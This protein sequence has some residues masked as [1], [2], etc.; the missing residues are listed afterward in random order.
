M[1]QW[2]IYF[3]WTNG[4]ELDHEWYPIL[5]GIPRVSPAKKKVVAQV[6]SVERTEAAD[7]CKLKI[8]SINHPLG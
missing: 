3:I 8:L 5:N 1:N 4:A 6:A 7:G 2:I